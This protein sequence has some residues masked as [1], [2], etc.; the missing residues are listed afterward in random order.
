MSIVQ[1]EI[2]RA[3]AVAKNSFS[4]NYLLPICDKQSVVDIK[5]EI[6]SQ[7]RETKLIIYEPLHP[8]KN[9]S[10]TL[11]SNYENFKAAYEL[12]KTRIEEEK[13]FDEK[14][15]HYQIQTLYQMCKYFFKYLQNYFQ[16]NS[17]IFM[18]AWDSVASEFSL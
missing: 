3:K 15:E 11:M 17:V 2:I 13:L 12:M 18:K 7:F 6:E 8:R 4:L 5:T 10:L 9:I 1:N 16:T 14:F